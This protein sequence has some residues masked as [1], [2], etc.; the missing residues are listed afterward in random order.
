MALGVGWKFLH[1]IEAS[2]QQAGTHFKTRRLAGNR[3]DVACQRLA[4]RI[5]LAARRGVSLL[6]DFPFEGNAFV[7]ALFKNAQQ[8]C[9][10]CIKVFLRVDAPVDLNQHSSGTTLKFAPPPLCPPSIRIE[11]RACPAPILKSVVLCSASRFS[12]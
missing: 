5:V 7:L 3:F 8:L 12:S 11:L 2:L 6:Q 4:E 9:L 1:G 10:L